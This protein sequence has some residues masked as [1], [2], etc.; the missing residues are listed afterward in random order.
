[1]FFLCIQVLLPHPNNPSVFL[2]TKLQNQY[3]DYFTRAENSRLEGN[4]E[5]AIESF[6][7]A[8]SLA[9]ENKDQRAQIDS[10]IKLGLLYWNNGN[11]KDSLSFYN[12]ALSLVEK[13]GF[14]DKKEEIENCIQIHDLYQA[15]KNHRDV[16]SLTELQKSVDSFEKAIALSKGIGSQ[17]HELKCLRQLSFSHG[18]SPCRIS[19]RCIYAQARNVKSRGYLP[20]LIIITRRMPN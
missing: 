19:A 6:T 18:C 1:M 4:Y 2:N 11:L 5:E 12:D 7:K 3:S 20:S 13:A 8:L 14:I 16:P 17:E 15:G 10:L 9:R